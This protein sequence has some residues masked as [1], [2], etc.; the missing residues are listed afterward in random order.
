MVCITDACLC[1]RNETH[2]ITYSLLGQQIPPSD[3]RLVRLLVVQISS[4]FTR[5]RG[6]HELPALLPAQQILHISLLSQSEVVVSIVRRD[7]VWVGSSNFIAQDLVQSIIRIFTHAQRRQVVLV[8]L[9]ADVGLRERVLL[10]RLDSL[11]PDALGVG[12]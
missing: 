4:E 6:L 1:M 7:L 8:R 2:Q 11:L 12:A 9:L 3:Q 10:A 5:V